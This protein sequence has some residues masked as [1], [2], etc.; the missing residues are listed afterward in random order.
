MPA[1]TED[2]QHVRQRRESRVSSSRDWYQVRLDNILDDEAR[3]IRDEVQ[4]NSWW[5]RIFRS[6]LQV[7]LFV[8]GIQSTSPEEKAGV[9]CTVHLR[10]EE[11]KISLYNIFTLLE[12]QK[13]LP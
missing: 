10:E 4:F 1:I 8:R 9:R 7:A 12:L 5:R 6:I 11:Y 2:M 13:A 3:K